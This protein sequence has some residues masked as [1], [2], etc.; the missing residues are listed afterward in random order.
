[1]FN[2]RLPSREASSATHLAR[3]VALLGPPPL[4]L[5]ERGT[6]SNNFFNENG[7]CNSWSSAMINEGV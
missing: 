2:E 1:M 5:L 7:K 3:M 6:V 4:R